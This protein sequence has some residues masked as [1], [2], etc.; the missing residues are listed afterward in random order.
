VALLVQEH[1]A[2]DGSRRG[3][4]QH[5]P[6]TAALRAIPEEVASFQEE[7]HMIGLIIL[8]V[9]LWALGLIG[10]QTLGGLLHILLV[11]AVVLLILQ[12]VSGRRAV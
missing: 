8:L 6:H 1:P 7:L 9:V 5:E 3:A 10:G 2:V 11:I 12:L 4:P